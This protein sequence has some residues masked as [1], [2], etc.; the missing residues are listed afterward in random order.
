MWFSLTLLLLALAGL[1]VLFS[2]KALELSGKKMPFERFRARTDAFIANDISFYRRTVWAHCVS[3]SKQ[4]YFLCREQ[5]FTLSSSLLASLHHLTL[6]LGEYLRTRKSLP[7]HDTQ[8][9]GSVSSYL[10]NVLEYKRNAEHTRT[11]ADL[12]QKKEENN[13]A[14][15][16]TVL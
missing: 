2:C 16:S 14:H 9:K 8:A 11:S 10:K 5:L 12:T 15:G 7:P 3:F 1:T 6:R 13:S 4:G